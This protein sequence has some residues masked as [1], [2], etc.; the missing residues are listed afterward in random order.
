MQD[1]TTLVLLLH[2]CPVFS[3]DHQLTVLPYIKIA[4]VLARE[5]EGKGRAA[6]EVTWLPPDSVGREGI[7]VTWL[8][9]TYTMP[10]E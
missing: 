7:D 9:L 2:P 6:E 4:D 3:H 10:E 8:S 5:F 1:K